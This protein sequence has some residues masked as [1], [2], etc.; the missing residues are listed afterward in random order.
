MAQHSPRFPACPE[1]RHHQGAEAHGRIC[2]SCTDADR[3]DPIHPGESGEVVDWRAWADD[4]LSACAEG[5][6]PAACTD[7][8]PKPEV[9]REPVP[10]WPPAK[11]R[12]G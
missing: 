1:C 12:E 4:T 5:R 10:T 3:F 8:I 9:I 6:R 11:I 2:L 7:G